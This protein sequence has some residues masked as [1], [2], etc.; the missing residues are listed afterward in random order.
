MQ[1]AF[2]KFENTIIIQQNEIHKNSI[3]GQYM[4]IIPNIEEK[5]QH[6]FIQ[7][8]F[9]SIY[10][11]K[12]DTYSHCFHNVRVLIRCQRAENS[13]AK[14]CS[15][16]ERAS[17]FH[18]NSPATTILLMKTLSVLQNGIETYHRCT[19]TYTLCFDKQVII[20]CIHVKL[21]TNY[22]FASKDKA[23]T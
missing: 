19:A 16:S 15:F 22:K 10:Q 13:P 18:N 7:T 6:Y 9:C 21:P 1:M 11:K 4:Y 3:N 5:F 17:L 8:K 20:A 12:I 14:V 2:S 23:V